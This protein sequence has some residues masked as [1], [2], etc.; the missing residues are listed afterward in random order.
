MFLNW[1]LDQVENFIS[2]SMCWKMCKTPNYHVHTVTKNSAQ[3]IC[4]PDNII[5]GQH[6]SDM[7]GYVNGE[8]M[9]NI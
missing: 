2:A 6:M 5:S 7:Y 9:I 1:T 8:E 3:Y 4:W